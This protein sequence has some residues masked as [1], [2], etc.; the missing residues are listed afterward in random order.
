MGLLVNMISCVS[1]QEIKTQGMIASSRKFGSYKI[2]GILDWVCKLNEF[3]Q[4]ICFDVYSGDNQLWT[5]TL[6]GYLKLK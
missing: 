6:G 3:G 5:P 2:S 1:V 4:M